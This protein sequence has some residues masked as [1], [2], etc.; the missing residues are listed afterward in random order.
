VTFDAVDG[1][2]EVTLTHV[3]WG[4]REDGGSARLSY[5]TGWDVVL[6][7]LVDSLGVLSRSW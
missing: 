2:T 4:D 7:R 6:G 5:D 1:G 3:G